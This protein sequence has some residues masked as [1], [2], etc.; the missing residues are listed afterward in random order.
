MDKRKKYTFE[1]FLPG[2]KQ[3]I[4]IHMKKIILAS[5]VLLVTASCYAQQATSTKEV[6]NKLTVQPAPKPEL[7]QQPK[8]VKEIDP[9]IKELMVTRDTAK[10]EVRVKTQE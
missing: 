8:P 5:L 10:S 7:K 4:K 9:E 2:F 1:F 6:M 3:T